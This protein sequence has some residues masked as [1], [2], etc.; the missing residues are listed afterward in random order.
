MAALAARVNRLSLCSIALCANRAFIT[1]SRNAAHWRA[2]RD[3]AA[4]VLHCAA[5][6]PVAWVACL[7]PMKETIPLQ[8][9][10]EDIGRSLFK[11]PLAAP[12]LWV[13]VSMWP[14]LFICL[15]ACTQHGVI[16]CAAL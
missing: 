10:E 8:V 6:V 11:L 3:V 12:R 13:G 5:L 4:A 7:V 16:L 9:Q 15:E 14:Y 1:V 2:A